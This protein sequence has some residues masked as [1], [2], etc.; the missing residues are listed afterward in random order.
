MDVEAEWAR[1]RDVVYTAASDVVGPTVRKHQDWFDE[2]ISHVQSLLEEK[3][4][5]HRAL[6]NDPSSASKKDAFNAAKRTVQS[7]LP[8]NQDD[9]YSRQADSIQRY[10]DIKDVKNFYATL[11]AVYGPTTSSSSSPL[12][13]ADGNTMISDKEKI[14]ERWAEHFDSVLNR[15]SNINE[16][17]I[18]RLPQVPIDRSLADPPTEAEVA[19]AIKRLF[20][21]KAPGADSIP[22]EVYAAGRPKLIASLTSLFITMWTQEKLPQDFKDATIIHL[23]KRNGNGGVRRVSRAARLQL[24]CSA[25]FNGRNS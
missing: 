24:K 4:K 14:L 23:F 18:D 22:A 17:A 20:S 5:L 2:N 16:E 3:H 15:P 19:K 10:A 11:K 6:L 8:H 13:S 7:E 12:L 25:V 9:W 1:L 21:G